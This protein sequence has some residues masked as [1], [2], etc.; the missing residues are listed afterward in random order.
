MCTWTW[1][2]PRR[3]FV[4]I[5]QPYSGTILHLSPTRHARRNAHCRTRRTSSFQSKTE[6]RAVAP[7]HSVIIAGAGIGGLSAALALAQHGFGVAIVARSAAR[8]FED[9]GAALIAADGLWSTLR[10]NLGHSHEPRFARHSAWRAVAPADAVAPE[11]RVPAINLWL[12]SRAHLV[13]YPVRGGRL[14]NIVAI[15]RD[16]WREAGWSASGEREEILAR[17]ASSVWSAPARA[18]VAAP[19]DWQKWALFDRAPPAYWGKGAVTLLGDAAH[20][21]LP[22]LAHGAAMAIEDAAI[23]ANELA[24]TPDQAASAMRRY[25]AAR[26]R[27][28]ARAQG[29]ARR[30]GM[31]YHMGGA[32]AFLR[33]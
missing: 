29:A 6:A 4:R 30:N 5:V 19:R 2:M 21:M 25:E 18:I 10:E 26:Q 12:G 24:R 20:P 14:I 11:L 23:L 13:H 15:I 7:A 31:I 1:A 17:F 9:R 27:R 16:E 8:D 22:Y 3:S 33:G 32:E 28:T